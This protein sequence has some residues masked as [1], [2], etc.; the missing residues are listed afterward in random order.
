MAW[1]TFWAIFYKP[2]GVA[3]WSSHPNNPKDPGS[4]PAWFLYGKAVM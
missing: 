4:N 2:D 3:Q 1:A